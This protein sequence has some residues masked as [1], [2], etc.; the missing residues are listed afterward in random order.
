MG[1]DLPKLAGVGVTS[2]ALSVSGD[3]PCSREGAAAVALSDTELLL[4]GGGSG[5][6]CVRRWPK[7]VREQH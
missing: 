7:R 4:F 1:N 5:G 6:G 3:A 2:H